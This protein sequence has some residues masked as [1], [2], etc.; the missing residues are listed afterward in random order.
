MGVHHKQSFPFSLSRF[1]VRHHGALPSLAMNRILGGAAT[2]IVGIFFPIFLYEFFDLSIMMVI[3][4]FA[5]S[6]LSRIPILIWAAKI[7]SKTGLTASMFIGSV[8]WII[9]MLIFF[10]LDA[11]PTFF[12]YLLLAVSGVTISLISAFYWTPFHVDFAQF[13]TKGHRGRQIGIFYAIQR[14]VGVVAP[15]IGGALIAWVSYSASFLAAVALVILSMIP[16]AFLPRS[17]VEYEFGFWETFQKLFNKRFR[18]LTLSMIALGA[19]NIVGV[20]IWPIFLFQI[21]RGEYLEVGAFAAVIVVIS[22]ALQ[23]G[24]G[25]ILDKSSQ[26][27]WLHWGV[28]L[29]ALGWFM[30]AFVDTVAGVFAV[31]TFHSL[32]SIMMRTPLDVMT[33]EKAA[34]SGHYIDEYTTIREIALNIGRVLMLVLLIGVTAHVSIPASFIV[35]AAA[36][37]GVTFLVRY[38]ADMPS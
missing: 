16:L 10:T 11:V 18:F 2:G 36:S 5:A 22:L 9:T 21:F 3:G 26:K 33:Y 27:K 25:K 7:F 17:E 35:A 34:D 37:F 30:K 12:P 24:L 1:D 4:W 31:S 28:D 19:E 20:V 29:Y 6:Y 13:S 14:L 32:G 15:M 23:L 8:W 38:H